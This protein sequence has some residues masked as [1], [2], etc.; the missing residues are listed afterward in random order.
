MGQRGEE[1]EA[2]RGAD[3]RLPSFGRNTDIEVMSSGAD[4]EG[5]D[6]ELEQRAGYIQPQR[7]VKVRL[8]GG[9]GRRR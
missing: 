7:H 4:V 6:E 3:G 9:G 5:L 2:E 8:G 1:R